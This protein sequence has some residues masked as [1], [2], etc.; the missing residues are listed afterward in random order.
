MS[1]LVPAGGS[2]N[3]WIRVESME[4]DFVQSENMTVQMT[5]RANAKALE[6]D[7]P[8]RVI[9]AQPTDPYQQIVWFKEERRELRFKFKS[10][11]INGDYQ[12]GQII[13]HIGEADGTVLGGVA[14]GS[15]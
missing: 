7:G 14:G 13:A 1:M 3:K 5:G 10:N 2:K 15:S 12:M 9:Y 11:T 4:P 6:V 8:E